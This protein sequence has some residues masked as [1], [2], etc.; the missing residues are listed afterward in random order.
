MDHLS[1]TKS[2]HPLTDENGN[3]FPLIKQF[4]EAVFSEALQDYIL[5]TLLNHL[6]VAGKDNMADTV[7]EVLRNKT[8]SSVR[9]PEELEGV[10]EPKEPEKISE[11][12]SP[13]FCQSVKERRQHIQ[14]GAW[15]HG[16]LDV[17]YPF[18]WFMTHSYQIHD[19]DR[20]EERYACIV[21]ALDRKGKKRILGFYLSPDN[22]APFYYSILDNLYKRGIRDILIACTDTLV[23]CA[24]ALDIFYPRTECQPYLSHCIRQAV[25][26]IAFGYH[27]RFMNDLK[28]V[29]NADS[30]EAA[31]KAHDD[32]ERKW[33]PSYPFATRSWNAGWNYMQHWFDYPPAIRKLL[34]STCRYQGIDHFLYGLADKGEGFESEGSLSEC[35]YSGLEQRTQKWLMPVSGWKEAER[36]LIAYFGERMEV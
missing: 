34:F 27:S 25:S 33:G 16:S 5:N 23:E 1:N 30:H 10:E 35:L 3:L 19:Q 29:W 26:H 11:I 24:E 4:T 36:Q 14:E 13:F 2:S 9:E 22:T 18:V 15:Q 21:V 28:Q 6:Q 7:S 32:L 17:I 8:P 12:S 31:R 20:K